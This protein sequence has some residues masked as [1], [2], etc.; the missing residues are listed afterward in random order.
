MAIKDFFLS[1]LAPILTIV[2]NPYKYGSYSLA[3][4]EKLG[5]LLE[6]S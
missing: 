4:E 1:T 6:S 5:S 2:S 3:T